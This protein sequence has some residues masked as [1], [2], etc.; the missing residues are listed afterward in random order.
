M[1]HTKSEQHS[2]QRRRKLIKD[3]D[4]LISDFD[5]STVETPESKLEILKPLKAAKTR[6]VNEIKELGKLHHMKIINNL[7]P[8][9]K[10]TK[11]IDKP[12]IAIIKYTGGDRTIKWQ[13][14][15]TSHL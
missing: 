8:N 2:I 11:I 12:F 14:P 10:I 6:A 9:A 4:L 7:R 13:K 15:N 1:L 3:I 5:K